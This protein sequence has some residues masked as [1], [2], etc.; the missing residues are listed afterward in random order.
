MDGENYLRFIITYPREIEFIDRLNTLG[1]KMFEGLYKRD[2]I[3][4]DGELRKINPEFIEYAKNVINGGVDQK[5]TN[6]TSR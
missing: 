5:E 2:V 4:I 6:L 3:L 1:E